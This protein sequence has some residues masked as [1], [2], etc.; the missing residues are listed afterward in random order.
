MAVRYVTEESTVSGLPPLGEGGSGFRGLWS[1]NSA[2]TRM[3][4]EIFKDV[5][6][7]NHVFTAFFWSSVFEESLLRDTEELGFCR[8]ST[9]T[10]HGTGCVLL[11]NDR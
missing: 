4:A 7:K 8:A 10:M 1:Q 5:F 6:G 11:K 2:E 9:Q 3:G